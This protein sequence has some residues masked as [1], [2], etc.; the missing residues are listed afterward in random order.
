MLWWLKSCLKCRSET[1]TELKWVRPTGQVD[2]GL[3][4]KK[5]RNCRMTELLG[6]ERV[7]VVINRERSRHNHI[8]DGSDWCRWHIAWQ[9]YTGGCLSKIWCDGVK[10]D[11][12]RSGQYRQD[13][14]V[15]NIR[16]MKHKMAAADKDHVEN[17]SSNGVCMCICVLVQELNSAV[18]PTIHSINNV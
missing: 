2:M 4:W 12:N 10:E 15:Q 5:G 9:N 13:R 14:Q 8:K 17:G 6:M 7:Q 11:M 1:H 3:C 18:C 16:R